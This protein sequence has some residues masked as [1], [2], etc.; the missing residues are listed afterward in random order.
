[1]AEEPDFLPEEQQEL[2]ET[3]AELGTAAMDMADEG[4]NEMIAGAEDIRLARDLADTA[5]AEAMLG[6]SDITR[7]VDAGIVADRLSVLSDVVAAAGVNDIN[8]GAELIAAADDVN[9]V[10][11]AVGL[12]TV[13]D[14][15]KGLELGR[16]SGELRILGKIVGKLEM[17]VLSAVLGERSRAS[18][19]NRHRHDSA[20]RRHTQPDRPDRGHRST[21]RRDG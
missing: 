6:A 11:A 5:T 13:D 17:P 19:R 9:A 16:I 15:D 10:S 21:H 14:L 7:A 18:V 12:M 20:R 3:A 4:L 8:Q 1:M 2:A